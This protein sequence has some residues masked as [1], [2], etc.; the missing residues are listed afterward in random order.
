LLIETIDTTGEANN[1][2]ALLE[3]YA[4]KMSNRIKHPELWA[5][6]EE[7]ARNM[8]GEKESCNGKYRVPMPDMSGHFIYAD[9]IVLLFIKLRHEWYKPRHNSPSVYGRIQFIVDNF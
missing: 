6:F 2:A 3:Q 9:C 5:F 1:L 7:H 4:E 8:E